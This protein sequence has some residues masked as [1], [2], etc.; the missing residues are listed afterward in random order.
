MRSTDKL[1]ALDRVAARKAPW[2]GS[3]PG[4]AQVERLPAEPKAFDRQ[5]ELRQRK[6][7]GICVSLAHVWS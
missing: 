4:F 1:V 5:V 3:L 6:R 2:D 7:P